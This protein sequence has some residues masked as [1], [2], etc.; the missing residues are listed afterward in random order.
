ML[1]IDMEFRKGILFVRLRGELTDHTVDVMNRE[2]TKTVEDYGIG[3]LVFNIS[4]LNKIDEIGIQS[5]LNNSE[6]AK[7]SKGRA[8][9]CGISNLEL[10]QVLKRNQVFKYMNETSDELTALSI[11]HV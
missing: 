3:N 2:V 5:I 7:R 4:D 9:L 6:L 1:E 10:K 11:I 8:L